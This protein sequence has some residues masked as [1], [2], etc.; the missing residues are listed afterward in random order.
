MRIFFFLIFWIWFVVFAEQAKWTEPT[1]NLFE[2]WVCLKFG[3]VRIFLIWFVV[4]VKRAKRAESTRK[5][6]GLLEFWVCSYFLDLI[7]ISEVSRA[8]SETFGFVQILGLFV[9]F[10]LVC[11]FCG[12][13]KTCGVHS[14]TCTWVFHMSDCL[15]IFIPSGSLCEKNP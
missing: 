15:Q 5:V 9:F 2:F 3:F 14:E 4:F 12:A 10:N 11:C 6:L 1:R 7:W 13:S 8:R